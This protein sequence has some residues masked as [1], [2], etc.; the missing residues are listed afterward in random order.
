[1]PCARRIPQFNRRNITKTRNFYAPQVYEKANC[2]PCNEGAVKAREWPKSVFRL[3]ACI[4]RKKVMLPTLR[5]EVG[6]YLKP[7]TFSSNKIDEIC[8]YTSRLTETKK[9][10][11]FVMDRLCH[12]KAGF[13]ELEPITVQ[14]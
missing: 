10:L 8:C 11:L 1:M 6:F 3:S 4:P 5:D 14:K 2:I 13:T 7:P 9:L 12:K